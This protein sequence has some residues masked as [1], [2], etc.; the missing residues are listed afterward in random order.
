[1][2][3]SLKCREGFNC[4]SRVVIPDSWCTDMECI[5]AERKLHSRNSKKISRR[6][7]VESGW[8]IWYE[9][10]SEKYDMEDKRGSGD[11]SPCRVYG[12]ALM[13]IGGEVW[14]QEVT[15]L[16]SSCKYT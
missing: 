10:G 8:S 4:E 14:K 16:K 7:T 12:R 9:R 5:R 11:N 13:G 2:F 6:G 3:L 1:M 15:R